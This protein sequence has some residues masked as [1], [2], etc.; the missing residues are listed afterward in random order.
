MRPEELEA[1][2]TDAGADMRAVLDEARA[3]PWPEQHHAHT[4]VQ[5]SGDPAAARST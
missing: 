4:D 2:R 1:I 3:T 5:D